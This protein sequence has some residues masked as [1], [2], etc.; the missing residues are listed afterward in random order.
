MY[1]N[2]LPLR[3]NSVSEP[4]L[5][6]DDASVII[7]SKNFNGFCSLSNLALCHLINASKWKMGFN[8]G[9]KGLNGLLLII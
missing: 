5:F 6:A 1:I 2:D 3:I 4:V 9:F 8:S 7:A